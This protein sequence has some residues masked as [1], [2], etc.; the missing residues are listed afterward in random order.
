[1]RTEITRTTNSH[2]PLPCHV[3]TSSPPL[4]PS[5][6]MI[7]PN[8]TAFTTSPPSL[9]LVGF[10]FC[11]LDK[12]LLTTSILTVPSTQTMWVDF[13][14]LNIFHIQYDIFGPSLL[15]TSLYTLFTSIKKISFVLAVDKNSWQWAVQCKQVTSF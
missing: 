11:Y 14:F 15:L 3:A 10:L 8:P 1:M 4:M 5:A 13:S 7:V 9:V 12:S 2:Q 6:T